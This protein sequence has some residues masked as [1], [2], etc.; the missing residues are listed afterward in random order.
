MSIGTRASPCDFIFKKNRP[1]FPFGVPSEPF[2]TLK[3]CTHILNDLL[4][5][6]PEEFGR[7]D[8]GLLNLLCAPAL[9]GSEGLDI[10]HCLKRLDGLAAF[11]GASA[12]RNLYRQPSDP[13][14]G[15]S[16]SMWRMALLVTN[17]K[18]NFGAGYSP[19]AKADLEAGR[20]SPFSDSREVFIHG[21]LADDPR[22][23]W[24]TCTSIPVLV[25]TIARR[26]G[27]PVGLAVAHKHVYCR[28]EGRLTFNIESSNPAGMAAKPDE[29][30]RDEL[31]GGLQ[32]IERGHGFYLRTLLPSEEFGLFLMTRATCLVDAGRY[33]EAILWA[34]RALQ[35]CPDD[36]LLPVFAY[37]A[38]DLALVHRLRQIHPEQ[39]IPA[40]DDREPF[41][42]RIDDLVSIEEASLVCSIR[43]HHLESRGE[44]TEARHEYEEACRLNYHGNNEQRD[45][46]R[47]LR[48]HGLAKKRGLPLP[49]NMDRLRYVKLLNRPKPEQEAEVLRRIA[50]EFARQGDM[51]RARNALH[52]VYLFDPCDAEVFQQARAMERH[53]LF[54]SQLQASF[55]EKMNRTPNAEPVVRNVVTEW[56][57]GS[58]P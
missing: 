45:L 22:Q 33:N 8:M 46:Q 1:V 9:P 5:T 13:D 21:L 10:P 37:H 57:R 49:A 48:K 41:F 27:Y 31:G 16:E 47:F 6:P 29:Y 55:G 28:W 38:L 12:E 25:A 2:S 26:L 11:V 17:V 40:P 3:G 15:H 19:K 42:F 18:L 30:Y 53:P 4:E 36:P 54:E 52:D 23:R 35:F 56:P 50:A 51:L 58:K 34:A 24:G 32:G 7:K 20:E 14:Y 43:A 39:K 44:L